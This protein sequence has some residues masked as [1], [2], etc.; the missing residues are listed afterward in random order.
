MGHLTSIKLLD[1][2]T[3]A[4]PVMR[5]VGNCILGDEVM[6]EVEFRMRESEEEE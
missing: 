5:Q 3:E 6:Q 1:C 2:M 4:G